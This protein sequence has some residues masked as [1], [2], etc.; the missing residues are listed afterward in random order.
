MTV[1][2]LLVT[3]ATIGFALGRHT[4][5]LRL[6]VLTAA[7]IALQKDHADAHLVVREL[8]G[9]LEAWRAGGWDRLLSEDAKARATDTARQYRADA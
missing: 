1:P 3:I 5:R 9:D 7:H 8:H 6:Y 2:I 4:L